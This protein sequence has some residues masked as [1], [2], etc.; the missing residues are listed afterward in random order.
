MRSASYVFN[1]LAFSASKD[2]RPGADDFLP[3]FIFI[4]LKA[5]VPHL[6]SNIEYISN[7][8]NPADLMSKAGYCFVNLCSAVEFIERLNAADLVSITEE[9]FDKRYQEAKTK[10]MEEIELDALANQKG[11]QTSTGNK[12]VHQ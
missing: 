2:S 12:F 10:L 8:R 1:Q 5:N 7:Y 4:V 9:E 11:P 6:H 3:A